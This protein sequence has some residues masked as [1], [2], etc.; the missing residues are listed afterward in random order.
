MLPCDGA[1][2][3]QYYESILKSVSA[4]YVLFCEGTNLHSAC[5]KGP[6]ETAGNTVPSTA[7][8]NAIAARCCSSATIHTMYQTTHPNANTLSPLKLSLRQPANKA[9]QMTAHLTKHVRTRIL[10]IG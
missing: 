3:R 5:A 1:K 9:N 7:L 6:K 10:A 8:A 4:T 2:S